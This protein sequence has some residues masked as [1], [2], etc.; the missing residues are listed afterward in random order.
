M[1]LLASDFDGTLY[2][3]PE[4]PHIR[5]RD[6][7]AIKNFQQ[8][9]NVFGI[10]TGRDFDSIHILTK[11]FLDFDFYI[12]DNGSVIL[13]QEREVIAQFDLQLATIKQV[14]HHF[15]TLESMVVTDRTIYAYH[16]TRQW[17][18]DN[19]TLITDPEALTEPTAHRVSFHLESEAHAAAVTQ[20]LNQ[21]G[22][23]IRGFQNGTEID[24]VNWQTS[25]GKALKIIQDY[26]GLADPDVGCIGDSYNDLPMLDVCANGFTFKNSPQIVRDHA[27]YMVTSVDQAIDQLT[28][29]KAAQAA[30]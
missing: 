15:A 17:E 5:T 3:Y 23:P 12:L 2:F 21:L 24:C 30:I 9:G 14:L 27:R 1:K 28:A 22:L 16:N 6:L 7:A 26:Y 18:S 10:C 29:R 19:I 11:D 13:N 25:K 20:E 8:A 4:D